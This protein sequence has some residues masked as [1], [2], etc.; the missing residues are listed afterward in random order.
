MGIV[1]VFI[2]ATAQAARSPAVADCTA[3][4]R[5]TQ[6]Y[7]VSQLHT[8]LAQM[9]ADVQEYTNCYAIIQRALL[10]GVS[11]PAGHRSDSGTSSSGGSFL[12]TPVIVVIV[13]VALAGAA[14]LVFA[15]RR[16]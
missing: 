7:T 13:L 3:H 14:G 4:G 8:A 12:P 15:A 16:R 6:H 9:P 10:A 2:P 5:L 11:R 1:L